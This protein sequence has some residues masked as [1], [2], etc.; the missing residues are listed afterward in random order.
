MRTAIFTVFMFL[1][2]LQSALAND[3]QVMTD[4]H[5]TQRDARSAYRAAG[6]SFINLPSRTFTVIPLA[7][8]T[9]A[10]AVEK[11]YSQYLDGI[12]AGKDADAA[13]AASAAASHVMRTAF[14]PSAEAVIAKT[15]AKYFDGADPKVAKASK[16]LGK[17]AA[18]AAMARAAEVFDDNYPPYKPQTSAGVYIT[19]HMPAFP[20]RFLDEKPWFIES[21]TAVRAAAP[22]A[23]DSDTWAKDFNEVKRLGRRTESE[24]TKEQEKEALFWVGQSHEMIIDQAAERRNWS[25]LKTAR[26]Y[27]LIAM[28]LDDGT[29]AVFESKYHHNFWRPITSIRRAELDGRDDTTVDAHWLPLRRTPNHPEYPCAHC[30]RGGGTAGILEQEIELM[31][32]ETFRVFDPRTPDDYITISSFAEFEERMSMSRIYIG[33]H[34]RSSNEA[35]EKMGRDVA[36]IA[37]QKFAVPLN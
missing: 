13:L 22:G 14:G 12:K 5:Q 10:N 17:A 27:A 4:W 15:E 31:D 18:E 36:K 33:A 7:M 26:L 25:L 28:S 11:E 3:W 8:F 16:E 20:E 1:W 2:S 21:R 30:T 37:R 24:R 34:Y 23:L 32:G 29:L 9:A 35:G 6:N 19:P